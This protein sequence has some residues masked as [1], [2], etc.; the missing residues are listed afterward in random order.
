MSL[1]KEQ[2]SL[3]LVRE[4][5]CLVIFCDYQVAL[6]LSCSKY[7]HGVAL[8]QHCLYELRPGCQ[9]VRFSLSLLVSRMYFIFSMTHPFFLTKAKRNSPTKSAPAAAVQILR[10]MPA[11]APPGICHKTPMG[12]SFRI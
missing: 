2:Q 5:G 1:V 8:S 7:D 10:S 6:S 4:G 12:I 11:L 3:M 9:Q